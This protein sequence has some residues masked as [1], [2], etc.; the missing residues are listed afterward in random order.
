MLGI[1][2]VAQKAAAAERRDNAVPTRQ[3]QLLAPMRNAFDALGSIDAWP[4][5]GKFLTYIAFIA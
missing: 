2:Q 3:S 5:A 1:L 4:T